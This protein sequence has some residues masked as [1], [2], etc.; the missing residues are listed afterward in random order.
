MGGIVVEGMVH[1][2][3]IPMDT[4]LILEGHTVVGDIVVGGTARLGIPTVMILAV[5]V[6]LVAV[7]VVVIVLVMVVLVVMVVLTF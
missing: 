1:L 6:V 4:I 2:L 3:V 7:V 5:V